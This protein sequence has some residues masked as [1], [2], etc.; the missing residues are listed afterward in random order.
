MPPLN[1]NLRGGRFVHL[2]DAM[3]AVSNRAP[4]PATRTLLEAVSRRNVVAHE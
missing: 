3:P 4:H 1:G 2:D